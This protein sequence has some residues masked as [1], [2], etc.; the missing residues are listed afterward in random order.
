MPSFHSLFVTGTDTNVGKTWISC[1]LLR[2]LTR[3]GLQ[4]GAYKPAC[5]GAVSD[6]A[7]ELLWEDLQALAAACP[8][9]TPAER[10]C[11][12]TFTAPLAPN[13]AARLEN[14]NVNDELLRSAINAWEHHCSHLVIEGAG[15]L[16]CPLSD[17]T[18][19]LDLLVKLQR[20]AP[21]PAVIV[22]ANR[23]GVISHTRLTV[24]TLQQHG[25]PVAGVI[26]N[27]A[28]EPDTNAHPDDPSTPL[29]AAQLIHWMPEIPL[30]N[31]SWN[32]SD[33]QLLHPGHRSISTAIEW[34]LAVTAADP[35]TS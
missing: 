5:S 33:L 24:S 2:S 34:L 22:A 7:G 9:E 35:Q 30:L 11:P 31:C 23:L 14:R 28:T 26:L 10:I 3:L 1:L 12:Q 15:G 13:E 16:F 18:T 20:P 8:P 4:P 19:V 32:A 17:Q 25:I 29:N 21:V 27:Q 6:P